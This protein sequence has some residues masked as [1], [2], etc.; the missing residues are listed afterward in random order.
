MAVRPIVEPNGDRMLVQSGFWEETRMDERARTQTNSERPPN[1]V[2]EL[3]LAQKM[4]AT[5]LAQRAGISRAHLHNIELNRTV[6][7]VA[8]ASRI[9]HVLGCPIE[10]VF[11][12]WNQVSHAVEPVYDSLFNLQEE[13]A[14]SIERDAPQQL[15]LDLTIEPSERENRQAFVPLWQIELPVDDQL[16]FDILH[17]G[18]HQRQSNNGN[19]VRTSRPGH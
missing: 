15:A 10:D 8:V 6:P 11:P 7:S 14:G 17:G 19:G 4:T 12:A 2:R 13:S 9:A 16:A 1:R 5:E 18:E 3:R